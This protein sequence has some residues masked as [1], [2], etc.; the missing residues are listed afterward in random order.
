M[1]QPMADDIQ[2]QVEEIKEGAHAR[3][4][5]GETT[6]REERQWSMVFDR[7]LIFSLGFDRLRSNQK[8]KPKTTNLLANLELFFHSAV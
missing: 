6:L 7:P 3:R 8:P 5:L 2:K 4:A 1:E